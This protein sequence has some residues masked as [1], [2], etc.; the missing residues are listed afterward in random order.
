MLGIVPEWPWV[1]GTA[2]MS[3]GDRL[4]LF[5]DGVTEAQNPAGALWDDE[6]LLECLERHP[7]ASARETLD[8]IVAAVR[9]FEAGGPASDDVTLLVARREREADGERS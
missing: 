3:A 5:T 2:H 7:R 9:A 4:V 1:Q 8:V 6:G